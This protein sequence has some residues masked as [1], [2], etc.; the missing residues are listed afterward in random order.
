MELYFSIDIEADGRIPG[1]NSMLSFGC[2]V[3]DNN[4]NH[5]DSYEVNLKTL[6]EAKPDKDT[7]KWWSTQPEAWKAHRIGIR[8]PE[9]AMPE[10]VAWINNICNKKQARPVFVGY[11]CGFDFTFMYWY[12]IKFADNS[13]FSFSA[14][15]IKSFAMAILKT[16]FRNTTKRNFPKEWFSKKTNHTHIALD[17][18]IEQGEMFCNMLKHL[19]NKN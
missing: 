17:D 5:I 11:P 3:F 19:N 10:F 4:G 2:A 13:P 1:E 9:E 12:L 16:D 15:D 8:D 6:P 18:A 14:L 7:M